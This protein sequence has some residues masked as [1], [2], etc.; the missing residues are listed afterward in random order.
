MAINFELMK[1]FDFEIELQVR[2]YE[3]DI[4][5]I[6]NNANYMHYLE[7]CRHQFLQSAGLSFAQFVIRSVSND[8]FLMLDIFVDYF[9]Q[10]KLF[11]VSQFLV[12]QELLQ[13]HPCIMQMD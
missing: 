4:Q 2:D 1:E 13:Y 3:C 12:V 5:G 9:Q 10:G 7:H 6:V 11:R 8:L